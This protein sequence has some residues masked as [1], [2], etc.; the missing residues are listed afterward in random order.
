MMKPGAREN[1]G[2]GLVFYRSCG[3]VNPRNPRCYTVELGWLMAGPG[4]GQG[5]PLSGFFLLLCLAFLA[6]VFS[7]P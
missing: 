4:N 3:V 5:R 7:Y 6:T 1:P 2:A